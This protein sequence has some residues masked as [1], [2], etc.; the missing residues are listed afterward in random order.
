MYPD[1]EVEIKVL[2]GLPVI[3]QVWI[4]PADPSVGYFSPS[5]EE[6]IL[7][8]HKTGKP[9]N[10]WIYNRIEQDGIEKV[11]DAIW[12]ALDESRYQS[13]CDAAESRIDDFYYP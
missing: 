2:G 1:C 13:E 8:H 5:I 6:Y 12:K 9:H 10:Q 4:D 7:C 3:A 11:E